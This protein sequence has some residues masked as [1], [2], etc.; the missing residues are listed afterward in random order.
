[1]IEQKMPSDSVFRVRGHWLKLLKRQ[2]FN[3]VL[4]ILRNFV[5]GDSKD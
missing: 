3:L 1:M 4:I 2:A 5:K